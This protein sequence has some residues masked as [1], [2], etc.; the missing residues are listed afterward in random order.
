MAEQLLTHGIGR[1]YPEPQLPRDGARH[2]RLARTRQPHHR[3]HHRTGQRC[4]VAARQLEVPGGPLGGPALVGRAELRLA[5]AEAEH[6]AAHV[7][8]IAS[9]EREK[10]KE[11]RVACVRLVALREVVA[12]VGPSERIQIHGEKGHLAGHVAASEAVVEL[13]AVEDAD[14]V[15]DTHAL[16]AHVP[17]PVDDSPLP[18]ALVEHGTMGAE[19]ARHPIA[20]EA[21]GG[22]VDGSADEGLGLGEVL[23]PVAAGLLPRAPPVDVRP[24]AGRPVK[25]VQPTRHPLDIR[26]RDG[27][28]AHHLVQHP[29]G[30][31][32]L[33]E[34]AILD[35]LARI[36]ELGRAVHLPDWLD[37]Q[38]GLLAQSS[39][40]PDLGL[41]RETAPLERR[42]VEKAE[43]HGLLQLQHAHAPDEDHGDVCLRHLHGHGPLIGPL[44]R[45][46]QS[47]HHS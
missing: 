40:Q 37:L 39:I 22:G 13:D 27:V 11:V 1:H 15:G 43:V 3:D 26:L 10:A 47:V 21:I 44:R 17:V 34:D 29:L 14:A 9:V 20:K 12:Q 2:R 24:A 5:Q 35:R 18:D 42:V 4:R 25:F 46:A 41:A 38:I 36:R 23:V 31:Q 33:H 45:I 8:P 32:P 30:G 6:L 19:P 28:L 16:A 7:R